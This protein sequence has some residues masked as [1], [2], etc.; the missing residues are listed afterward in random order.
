M[1]LC[2]LHGHD[3]NNGTVVCEE[4]WNSEYNI[5]FTSLQTLLLDF[6]H[7]S[8][9]NIQS[10]RVYLMMVCYKFETYCMSHQ[11]QAVG[12]FSACCILS[13]G[14]KIAIEAEMSFSALS[15]LKI[16]LDFQ[17]VIQ[18]TAPFKPE[19]RLTYSIPF[20]HV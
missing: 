9:V 2:S 8:V 18:F 11:C 16:S 14:D 15:F 1:G 4:L 13:S 20:E 6:F 12:I 10:D 19:R 17:F 5:T 3:C 7:H